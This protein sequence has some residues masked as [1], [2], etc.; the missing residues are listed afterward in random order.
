MRLVSNGSGMV[1]Q[2]SI[3]HLT[4]AVHKSECICI[5]LCPGEKTKTE[6]IERRKRFVTKQILAD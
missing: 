5:S 4:G 3:F 2:V 6:R 1:G